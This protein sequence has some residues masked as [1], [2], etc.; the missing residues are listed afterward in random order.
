MK[1]RVGCYLLFIFAV[2]LYNCLCDI[3]HSIESWINLCTQ[4]SWLMAVWNGLRCQWNAFEVLEFWGF[5]VQAEQTAATTKMPVVWLCI[6]S[7][8]S[9]LSIITFSLAP[10]F[11][12][13]KIWKHSC[14]KLFKRKKLNI[15]QC[16]DIESLKVF[17]VLAE[18][19]TCF[20]VSIAFACIL[21]C[22]C[23]KFWNSFRKLIDLVCVMPN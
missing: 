4:P 22:T 12:L 13:R 17:V 20:G 1:K 19:Y 15:R 8:F 6:H 5:W 16:L 2:W 23:S 10:P 9:I 3:I 11:V 18:N 7:L 14:G 21:R